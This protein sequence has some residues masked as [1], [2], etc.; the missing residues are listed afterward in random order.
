RDQKCL[1]T[2][3]ITD[4]E[5]TSL[6]AVFSDHYLKYVL[7]DSDKGFIPPQDAMICSRCRRRHVNSMILI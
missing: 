3:T 2:T 5:I 4:D 7:Y 6:L 1:D